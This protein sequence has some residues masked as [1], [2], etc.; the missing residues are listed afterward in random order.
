V[1]E[2]LALSGVVLAGVAAV[3]FGASRLMGATLGG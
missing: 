1:A 2:N 3:T